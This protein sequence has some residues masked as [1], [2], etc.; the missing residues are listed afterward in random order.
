M[1]NKTFCDKCDGMVE[2]PYKTI[3]KDCGYYN[4]KTKKCK[5]NYKQ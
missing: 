2:C 4:K 5:L 1:S 3:C